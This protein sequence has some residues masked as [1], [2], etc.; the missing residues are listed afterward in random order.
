MASAGEKVLRTVE[1]GEAVRISQIFF[2]LSLF[3]R[4]REIVHL[5]HV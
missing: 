3:L 5:S 4:D 1:R 2:G